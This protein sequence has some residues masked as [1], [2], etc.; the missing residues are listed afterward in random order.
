MTPE[1]TLS[2]IRIGLGVLFLV[3]TTIGARLFGLS[4]PNW[5][6]GWPSAGW[7]PIILGIALPS[8]VI[9]ALCVL[10]TLGAIAFV[11]GYRVRL[12]GLV[13]GLCG[14]LVLTQD[15]LA[16][17]NTMY[18]LHVGVVM[19]ALSIPDA[20]PPVRFLVMSVYAW[21]GIAKLNSDWLSGRVLFELVADGTIRHGGSLLGP[22]T[23]VVA[24]FAVVIV[25]LSL[26]LLLLLRRSRPIGLVA[27]VAFHVALEA[28]V[29]PDVFGWA[30]LSL[31]VAFVGE[32]KPRM[33]PR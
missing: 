10:R 26:P 7:H 30:M 9:C 19:V 23:A 31:L 11:I 8:A 27:A 3:R 33:L 12:S 16:F 21:A 32:Q 6:Y 5:L 2:S 14:L 28:F 29:R 15:P 20:L 22:T 17:F 25:E 24:A 4:S 13:A 1:R 18:L